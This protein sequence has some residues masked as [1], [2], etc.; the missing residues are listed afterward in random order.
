MFIYVRFEFEGNA[1]LPE[2]PR[3]GLEESIEVFSFDTSLAR[4]AG[5]AGLSGGLGVESVPGV[6]ILKRVDSATPVFCQALSDG[7]T[8]KIRAQILEPREDGTELNTFDVE[9]DDAVVVLQELHLGPLPADAGQPHVRPV[10]MERLVFHW[11]Q[12]AY[13]HHDTN[14]ASFVTWG[15]DP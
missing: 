10:H 13:T 2:S 12:M 11:S 1:L 15:L 6:E 3:P 4:R 14:T 5:R 9:L 7:R 8:F